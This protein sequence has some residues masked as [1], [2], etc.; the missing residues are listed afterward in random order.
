M[1]DKKEREGEKESR[2]RSNQVGRGKTSIRVS[3]STT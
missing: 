2:F 3:T 1:V